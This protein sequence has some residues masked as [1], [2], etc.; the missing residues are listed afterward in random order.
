[1]V[2]KTII[3]DLDGTLVDPRIYGE[4]YPMVIDKIKTDTGFSDEEL[5]DFLE[6]SGMRRYTNGRWDSG[7]LCRIFGL[8]DWY[9]EILAWYIK[10]ND[11]LYT[12]VEPMFKKIKEKG[13]R[14]I[15][16]SNS[17]HRT[18]KLYMDHYNL[19]Q[20]VD[21]I[22]SSNDAGFVKEDVNFWKI[23]IDI[24][25]IDSEKTVIVGDDPIADYETP[26]EAGLCAILIKRPKNIDRVVNLLLS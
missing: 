19:A 20:Y 6:K 5:D 18:I 7:Y 8:I 16:A 23:L 2:T 17:M 22:F 9:Y 14:I 21:Y 13:I 4:V 24:H 1:M 15:I 11:I 10:E 12:D 26:M 3:F 25:A